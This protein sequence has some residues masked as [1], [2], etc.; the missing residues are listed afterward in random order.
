MT[1]VVALFLLAAAAPIAAQQAQ[2]PGPGRVEGVV[3]DMWGRPVAGAEVWLVGPDLPR[4]RTGDDG[5]FAFTCVPVG[6]QWARAA[7][8][9]WHRASTRVHVSHD[10]PLQF[11]EV[12]VLPAADVG[13][14]VVDDTGAPVAGAEVVPSRTASAGYVWPT[15]DERYVTDAAGKILLQDLAL[16]STNINAVA[17]GFGFSSVRCYVGDGAEVVVKLPRTDALTLRLVLE[18]ATKAQIAAARWHLS[19]M[20]DGYGAGCTLPPSLAGGRLDADGTATIRGLPRDMELSQ[21][22]IQVADA[23]V[24]PRECGFQP[25]ADTLSHEAK[26]TAAPRQDPPVCG[27]VVDADGKPVPGL[28]LVCSLHYGWSPSTRTDDRGEFKFEHA[29]G[30]GQAFSLRSLDDRWVFDQIK[31]DLLEAIRNRRTFHGVLGKDR[32]EVHC[33]A[34]S[35]VRG[36]VVGADGRPVPGIGIEL[37][38]QWGD[39]RTIDIAWATSDRDGM[40]TLPRLNGA[41]EREMWIVANGRGGA[42]VGAR[43]VLGI[44]AQLRLPDLV[45]APPAVVTGTVRDARGQPVFGATVA[46][47]RADGTSVTEAISD[48]DG[49]FRVIGAAGSHRLRCFTGHEKDGRAEQ[50]AVELHSGETIDIDLVRAR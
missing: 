4:Q 26:F 13:V 27:V 39:K 12:V 9:G 46:L 47:C 29:V 11:A 20:R 19:A 6:Y 18:G 23:S 24:V 40:F 14:R 25:A 38:T 45:L 31:Q 21:I 8:R 22:G 16:G 1:H 35:S 30:L 5:V 3:I 34:A 48:R 2:A 43:F 41:D 50:Q 37:T 49:R 28:E 36:R 7:V 32:C 44:D 33:I 42:A 15:K 17:P 10:A